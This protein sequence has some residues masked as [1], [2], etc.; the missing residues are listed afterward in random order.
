[1]MCGVGGMCV[2]GVCYVMC[3]PCDGWDWEVGIEKQTGP[4]AAADFKMILF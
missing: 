3:T 4:P 1:M 2:W